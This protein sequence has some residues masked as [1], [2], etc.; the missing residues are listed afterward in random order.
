MLKELGYLYEMLY[1]L[2]HIHAVSQIP[3]GIV[4][5]DLR[6]TLNI[7]EDYLDK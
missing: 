4:I 7:L 6:M 5:R 1:S 2:Q 3:S